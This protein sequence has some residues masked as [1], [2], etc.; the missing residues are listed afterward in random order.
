M[1]TQTTFQSAPVYSTNWLRFTVGIYN[2]YERFVSKFK[3]VGIYNSYERVPHSFFFYW[4]TR[5]PF[6]MIRRVYSLRR[7][8]NNN[9]RSILTKYIEC[10]RLP[11][12]RYV[13]F[14]TIQIFTTEGKW[15]TEDYTYTFFPP[16]PRQPA[17]ASNQQYLYRYA[18]CVFTRAHCIL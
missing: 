3:C 2:L 14:Y 11:T 5:P 17:A 8:N 16:P 13:R 1:T 15:R 18:V 10:F 12:I 9:Y 4:E 6:M 7:Y